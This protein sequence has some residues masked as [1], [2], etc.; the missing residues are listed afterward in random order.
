MNT[1][2]VGFDLDALMLELAMTD[3]D[4]FERTKEAMLSALRE[5]K[6]QSE[7]EKQAK[8][9]ARKRL[10]KERLARK[11]SGVKSN[12]MKIATP[13]EPIRCYDDFVNIVDALRASGRNGVRDAT[14]F[15][16]GCATGLRGI[17]VTKLRSDMLWDENGKF[18]R[19]AYLIEQKTG[20]EQE[21]LITEVIKKYLQG[22]VQSLGYI[23]N[24]YVFA[25]RGGKGHI[26]PK[27]YSRTLVNAAK[28]CGIPVHISA[29]SMRY[30][31]AAIAQ[32]VAGSDSRTRA[33]EGLQLSMNHSSNRLTTGYAKH[34]IREETDRMRNLVSDFLLGRIYKDEFLWNSESKERR[35]E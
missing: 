7:D 34:I 25:G 16:V 5:M 30:S 31:F 27:S 14:I 32:K 22:Y 8:A 3:R 28:S 18:R 2:V 17:D 15:A 11:I 26:E 13:A 21:F 20:K 12:G 1:Q 9:E 33:L 19:R 29:H 23:P 4:N 35:Y 6:K 10:L 24:G